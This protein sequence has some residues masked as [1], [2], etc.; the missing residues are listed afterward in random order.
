MGDMFA[1]F[2]TYIARR[3]DELDEEA[4]PYA[5]DAPQLAELIAERILLLTGPERELAT[6]LAAAALSG[7]PYCYG[8]QFIETMRKVYNEGGVSDDD[9]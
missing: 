7:P 1:D 6:L 2:L 3:S 4:P 8:R 5:L 9:T